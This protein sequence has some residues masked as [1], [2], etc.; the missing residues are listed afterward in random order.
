MYEGD[1][2]HVVLGTSVLRASGND[3]H[4]GCEHVGA[5][6]VFGGHAVT[7]IGWCDGGRVVTGGHV[8]AAGSRPHAA[9]GPGGG[10]GIKSRD[11]CQLLRPVVSDLKVRWNP[12][13][14]GNPSSTL[15]Y[16]PT[17]H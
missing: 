15:K 6:H 14:I 11:S 2:A 17:S 7:M 4:M 5:T 8:L 3:M 9:S 1:D 10:V 16:G 13:A 12:R